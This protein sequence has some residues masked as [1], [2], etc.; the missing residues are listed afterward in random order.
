LLGS[1]YALGCGAGGSTPPAP[2]QNGGNGALPPDDGTRGT[3]LI[4]L[5]QKLESEGGCETA[6]SGAPRLR[7]ISRLEYDNAVRDLFGMTPGPASAFTAEEKVAGFNNNLTAPVTQLNN[8]Q[9][10]TAAESV[11]AHFTANLSALSGCAAASDVGCITPYLVRTAR[12]AFHGTLPAEEQT[13]LESEHAAVLAEL[14]A[15]AALDFALASILLSPR[16]LYVVELGES[17]GGIVR[18]TPSEIAGRLALSLW[19]SVPD[20]ALLAAADAGALATNEGVAATASSMLDDPRTIHMLSDF[21]GQWLNLDD[22]AALVKDTT[23][24]PSF[25]A[26]LAAA[27]RAETEQFFLNLF[28][29]PA[30]EVGQLFTSSHTYV[31]QALA[32]HYGLSVAGSEFTRVEQPADRRGILSHASFLSAQAHP[33][34]P[35]PVLRGKVIRDRVL[36]DPV[37]PPPPD[38]TPALQNDDGSVSTRDAFE[39]HASD[40]ACAYC[41]SKMDPIGNAFSRYD[42]IGAYAPEADASTVGNVVAP[43]LAAIHDIEGAFQNPVELA[44]MLGASEHVKQCYSIQTLRYVLNREEASGDACSASQAYAHF[45][46]SGFKLKEA[47]VG[48]ATSDAFLHRPA[49]SAGGTCP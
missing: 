18:L 24:Y 44:A 9:Y 36:C 27:F 42:A 7:R 5:G 40:P 19:R 41:H 29:D 39:Q 34:R 28:V 8:E 22:P 17:G 37:A 35:S 46:A 11:A 49:V 23:A 25:D 10:L 26:T 1:A 31:N 43:E 48:L 12:K 21:L 47:L 6:L 14:G 15:D 45:A 16:F 20:D 32:S 2:G 38:V 30:N 13:A 3:P 33:V 4:A